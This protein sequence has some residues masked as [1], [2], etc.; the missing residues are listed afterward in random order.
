MS[1]KRKR[2]KGFSDYLDKE[3]DYFKQE[4]RML[5][6]PMSDDSFKGYKLLIHAK[7]PILTVRR[8]R[9]CVFREHDMK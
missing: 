1:K 2:Q 9:F 3:V 5:F 4:L 6:K 7:V 8:R